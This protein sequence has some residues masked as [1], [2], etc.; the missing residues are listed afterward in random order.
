MK[1]TAQ[2]IKTLNDNFFRHLFSLNDKINQQK[3]DLQLQ[4]VDEITFLRRQVESLEKILVQEVN[5]SEIELEIGK[6]KDRALEL[7]FPCFQEAD[8]ARLSDD[9]FEQIVTIKEKLLILLHRDDY[10]YLEIMQ[11]AQAANELVNEQNIEDIN[12]PF[13]LSSES[14]T[15]EKHSPHGFCFLNADRAITKFSTT[16]SSCLMP[17]VTCVSP[18][19]GEEVESDACVLKCEPY[20]SEVGSLP[21]VASYN[22]AQQLVQLNLL[23]EKKP[24]FY[25][26]D[27]KRAYQLLHSPQTH[28][29]VQSISLSQRDYGMSSMQGTDLQSFVSFNPLIAKKSEKKCL[30]A[31]SE[32]FTHYFGIYSKERQSWQEEIAR[33]E[34]ERPF[35]GWRFLFGITNQIINLWQNELLKQQLISILQEMQQAYQQLLNIQIWLRQLSLGRGEHTLTFNYKNS[36]LNFFAQHQNRL[37]QETEQLR[38]KMQEH[39]EDQYGMLECTELLA[40]LGQNKKN[41]HLLKV[42]LRTRLGTQEGVQVQLP[43]VENRGGKEDWREDFLQANPLPDSMHF[44][45]LTE[46]ENVEYFSNNMGFITTL[47]K[48]LL[49]VITELFSKQGACLL[50]ANTFII[51]ATEFFVKLKRDSLL[52]DIKSCIGHLLLKEQQQSAI[53]TCQELIGETMQER[54]AKASK[55]LTELDEKI[56]CLIDKIK[57]LAN[58]N[59]VIL[60]YANQLIGYAFQE[61]WFSTAALVEAHPEL[62]DYINHFQAIKDESFSAQALLGELVSLSQRFHYQQIVHAY[63]QKLINLLTNDEYFHSDVLAFPST[64][65]CCLQLISSEENNPLCLAV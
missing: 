56:S 15:L 2:Q 57:S 44:T 21:V 31:F 32:W 41:K 64:E 24:S 54:L 6:I 10:N 4:L 47:H 38:Q 53:V 36:V 37:E 27:Q 11:G 58:I 28:T 13:D 48:A 8:L 62:G 25:L 33:V 50:Q 18:S 59:H 45:L 61:Y 52:N 17:H 39:R 20:G 51:Q 60:R 34:G 16:F 14:L 5:Q 35:W 26:F 43:P 29:I 1:L 63:Q 9:R 49:R 42:C 65:A 3:I 55:I 40:I 19:L 46:V 23:S 12:K 7:I 30:H 22:F